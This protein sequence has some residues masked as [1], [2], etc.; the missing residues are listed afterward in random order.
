MKKKVVL[1]S[2]A[3]VAI[4]GGVALYFKKDIQNVM[5]LKSYSA[6]FDNENILESFR[7]FYKKYPSIKIEKSSTPYSIPEADSTITLPKDFVFKGEAYVVADEIQKRQLISLLI[8]KDGKTIYEQ[9]YQGHEKHQPTSIFSCTKS[10]MALLIGICYE[11]GLIA[12]LA[13]PAVKYAPELKGTVYEDVRIQNILNMA[14]GVRWSENYADFKSEVVQ[15][16]LVSLTGS[17]NDFSKKMER[18]RE[19]GVFNQYTSMDTQILGM[20]IA[21]A[22]K[23]PLE[24]FFRENLWDKIHAQDDAYFLTDKIGDPIAYG[25]LMLST[26]DMA[27]IG[28]LMRNEG[29]NDMGEAVFSNEWIKESTTPT[30]SYQMPGKRANADFNEGYKNQW[31]FP[32]ERSGGDFSALGVFGQTLYINPEK[33]II[34]ASNSAYSGYNDDPKGD[35]RRLKMFQT[36]VE[37]ISKELPVDAEN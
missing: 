25:G 33:N 7:F 18:S 9:Y 28:L 21:G 24:T 19:Q 34:I 16:Y 6:N 32:E 10:L 13:D 15:S 22:S 35:S 23:T 3:F 20:I 14:S 37:H 27:K 11:K 1:I 4:I 29:K 8:I 36:I 26:R 12:S 30:E 17:L 2:L 5:V 31:W